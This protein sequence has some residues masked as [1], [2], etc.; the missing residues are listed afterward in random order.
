VR[1]H[2]RGRIQASYCLYVMHA[3]TDGRR[4]SRSNRIQMTLAVF[5]TY[6]CHHLERHR[7]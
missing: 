3:L 4:L 1:C 5:Q 7:T 2:R 6:H